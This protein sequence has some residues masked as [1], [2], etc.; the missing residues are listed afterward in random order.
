MIVRGKRLLLAS[1]LAFASAASGAEPPS[2]AVG[3]L[4]KDM[5]GREVGTVAAVSGSDVVV[6]TDRHEVLLPAGSMAPH[7]GAYLIAMSRDELNAAVETAA[8]PAA[9]SGA[10]ASVVAAAGPR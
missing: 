4:V 10:G 6:R 7:A 9:T 2:I 5:T 3:S 8:A 1:L